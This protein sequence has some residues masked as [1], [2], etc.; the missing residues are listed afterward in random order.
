MGVLS[1]AGVAPGVMFGLGIGVWA[2][3]MRLRPILVITSIVR[4]LSLASVPAAFALDVLLMEQLYG[5]A[6]INGVCRTFTSVSFGAYLPKVVGRGNLVE[7]N[8]KLAASGSVVETSAFS[9]GGW[10]AQLASAVATVI[11]EALSFVLSALFFLAIRIP[12]SEVSSE[13]EHRSTLPEVW[14]GLA[15][16]FANPV[17]RALAGSAVAEGLLHG[18]VG[19][20]ILIYGVREL[21]LDT[22]V[23]ATIFAVGG[24]SS[25]IG[26][27]YSTP[28]LLILDDLGLHRMTQQQSID[29][30]ELVIARHRTASFVITSNRA[31]DEWLGLFDDPILGNSALDGSPTPATRSS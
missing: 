11:T 28:D 8:S 24:I 5:V 3:R 12:E 14:E 18:G 15:F 1:G 31:V 29:L 13:D 19:A 17:L 7:A 16:V 25:L 10:I 27:T 20:V 6:L 4:A 21:G 22:G 9:V 23:L 30:Y 26:A 2:D